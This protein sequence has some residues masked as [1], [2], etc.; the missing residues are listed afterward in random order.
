M[1]KV[2]KVEESGIDKPLSR[3]SPMSE[4]G[5]QPEGFALTLR[6]RR[7]RQ[8]LF[9]AVAILTLLSLVAQFLI[10][11]FDTPIGNGLVPLI[12][13][14][15]E[16]NIP[17]LYSSLTLFA[18]GVLAWV[19]SQHARRAGE[20]HSRAWLGLALVCAL[21][22]MEEFVML[23]ELAN[24]DWLAGLPTGGIFYFAWVIPALVVGAALIAAFRPFVRDLDPKIRRLVLI[25]AVIFFGAA[26][27]IEM[28]E[29][30][31]ADAADGEK[32]FGR[33]LMTVAQE[34]LEMIAVVWLIDALILE[35]IRRAADPHVRFAS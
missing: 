6:R 16:H 19:I 28:L 23:H 13:T 26:V 15:A 9:V 27:G 12:N 4:R 2:A 3:E 30:V 25:S 14:D 11:R 33:G 8:A 32:T 17:T 7:L 24:D 35:L 21:A 10:Y 5:R 22:G 18:A 29:G 31:L 34:A 20:R 1:A